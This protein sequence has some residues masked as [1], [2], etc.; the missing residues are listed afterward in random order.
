MCGLHAPIDFR[1]PYH[2]YVLISGV[3]RLLQ[4]LLLLL[5]FSKKAHSVSIAYAESYLFLILACEKTVI[6][7]QSLIS[8]TAFCNW[9]TRLNEWHDVSPVTSQEHLC[10]PR[11]AINQCL[12]TESKYEKYCPLLIQRQT[13]SFNGCIRYFSLKHERRVKYPTSWSACVCPKFPF[14]SGE[15][16]KK[17]SLD[18]MW[19]SMLWRHLSRS[20]G[21][22]EHNPSTCNCCQRWCWSPQMCLTAMTAPTFLP[23]PL[24]WNTAHRGS[25]AEW[26][27]RAGCCPRCWMDEASRLISEFLPAQRP[28]L[29]QCA[30]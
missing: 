25:G 20:D 28:W 2:Y 30:T 4:S 10:F 5:K 11:T 23:N 9:G 17:I 7:E 14:R 19:S 29:N 15:Y 22:N 21:L 24:V 16:L 1:S 26:R 18:Y 6:E 12:C 27:E 8:T 3:S 13:P